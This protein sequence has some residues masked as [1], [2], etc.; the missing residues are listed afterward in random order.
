MS[1]KLMGYNKMLPSRI[2]IA[3]AI[4]AHIVIFSFLLMASAAAFANSDVGDSVA[5]RVP[6]L[7]TAVSEKNAKTRECTLGNAVS[8]AVRFALS[9]D[10]A[11]V[12]GGYLVRNLLPGYIAWDDL[13]AV[14]VEDYHL[15]SVE[16]TPKK[17]SEILEAGVSRITLDETESI[18]EYAS[19][20]DGFPQISGF[21]LIYD[22]SAPPGSR[23]YEIRIGGKIIDINDDDT[24]FR[25]AATKHMLD[26]GYGL[27]AIHNVESSELTLSDAFAVYM[28]HGMPEYRETELR[29]FPAGARDS[30]LAVFFPM[31]LALMAAILIILGNGQ[32]FRRLFDFQL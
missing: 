8:D 4:V 19:A 3:A 6:Q 27:P 2:I 5:G 32:R 14:F 25:L 29:I 17:L 21:T 31:G 11:I 18:D 28:N 9:A 12:C 7:L 30:L 26:G 1:K 15:A 13:R 24:L 22:A 16:V 20:Y 23:V 10:L